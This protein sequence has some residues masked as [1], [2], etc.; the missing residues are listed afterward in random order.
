MGQ[1]I[2]DKDDNYRSA[3]FNYIFSALEEGRV[4]LFLD[5][6]NEIQQGD[7][8]IITYNLISLIEKL[9]ENIRIFITGRK[10][11][12]EGSIY[13]REFNKIENVGIWHL[14]ELY[15][16]QIENFLSP[17]IRSQV[18]NGQME[19][20]F[21]SPLNIRL[22]LS[23]MHNRQKSE[24]ENVLEVPINRGEMLESFLADTIKDYND[25]IQEKKKKINPFY[26][27]KLLRFIATNCH[28]K[29]LDVDSIT[30]EFYDNKL[31]EKLSD[32][33][34]LLI[35]PA[36]NTTEEQVAFSIDTF[37]EYY[38]AK[39]V[40]DKLCNDNTLSLYSLSDDVSRLNPDSS[41]DFETLKLIF[42]VG[43]SPLY[44]RYRYKDI[45]VA[46]R[47]SI[48]FSARL[49]KDFLNPRTR[50]DNIAADSVLDKGAA[51]NTCGMNA[52]LLTLSRL[53][54]NIPFSK[55]IGMAG[56]VSADN[57]E[58]KSKLQFKCNS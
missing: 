56:E 32:L 9:P 45:S 28:G 53:T 2:I 8:N 41:E 10:Y 34:I 3:A 24:D 21:S 40:I 18:I 44:H 50:L 33:N 54:R 46:R 7:A 1:A 39:D 38:R 30:G 35:T 55:N 48:E 13:S 42:E 52:R 20:L 26:A 15:F 49:A 12:Y 19:E 57:N 14:E 37:Q 58:I 51:Y 27:T 5:G 43:S 31:L 11:E 29:P 25:N 4:V 22:F 16:E 17:Q 6:L 36:D 23:Y 47:K